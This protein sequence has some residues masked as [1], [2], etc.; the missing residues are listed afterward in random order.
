MCGGTG[1]R[2]DGGQRHHGLSPRVRGN[3][4]TSTTTNATWRSIPACAGEPTYGGG[5]T[6]IPAVYPRVCGGTLSSRIPFLWWTGL[7]PRV[8][9]NPLTA[10]RHPSRRRSIPAC[11][12]EP[13]ATPAQGLAKPVYP[14]VCGGTPPPPHWSIPRRGL[15]PRVRG[16]RPDMPP[17]IF[18]RGSI[19][20]CAGEPHPRSGKSRSGRVYP[21]V[22][23]GTKSFTSSSQ[24]PTGLSPRVRGNREQRIDI[25]A[26]GRSI[27]ACAGEPTNRRPSSV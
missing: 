15:S 20:A 27:P 17:K 26:G 9:G 18:I 7:S 22:C 24:R 3:R 12:G 5:F 23:G 21:R 10:A 25:A 8:R 6:R 2:P 16:N 11:A 13:A 19:P 1:D 14:R 4:S